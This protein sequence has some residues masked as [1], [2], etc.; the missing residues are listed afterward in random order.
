MAPPARRFSRR[1]RAD[2]LALAGARCE[3]CGSPIGRGFHADHVRP[4]V[5]GGPSTMA[6]G[7]ATCPAC[8][9]AKGTSTMPPTI[10]RPWQ[11]K[12]LQWLKTI[13][14][15]HALVA[16]CPGS[17]KTRLAAAFAADRLRDGH[18]DFVVVVVP[19]CQIKLQ[20]ARE[21]NRHGVSAQHL[22]GNHDL[23][24]ELAANGGRIPFQAI[25]VTYSQVSREAGLF[26]GYVSR[27]RTLA[28]LDEVHHAPGRW[29][30]TRR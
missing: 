4:F 6:N 13:Q 12:A 7:R 17:G 25:V 24:M 2:L 15:K 20:W 3:A 8:N 28:I 14:A 21:L 18:V 1:Q 29:S 5:R 11:R 23:R 16:A 9:L 10:L 30:S 26:D 22:A 19:T 27:N